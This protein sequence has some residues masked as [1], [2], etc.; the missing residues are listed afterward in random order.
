MRA[1]YVILLVI[2]LVTAATFGIEAL[3]PDGARIVGI[4]FC[5]FLV[6]LLITGMVVRQS[7]KRR[8]S[9]LAAAQEQ[10]PAGEDDEADRQPG[11]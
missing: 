8:Q 3:G 9:M 5:L 10:P 7:H 2:F 6:F 4:A 11:S 1:E